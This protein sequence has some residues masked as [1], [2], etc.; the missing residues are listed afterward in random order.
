MCF[1]CIKESKKKKNVNLTIDSTEF[2]KRTRSRQILFE[3]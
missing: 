2:N 3:I 1:E